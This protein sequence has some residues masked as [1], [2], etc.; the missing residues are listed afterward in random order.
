MW[1]YVWIAFM[2]GLIVATTV[3]GLREKKARDAAIKKMR[4]Q[5]MPDMGMSH[6]ASEEEGFGQADPLDGFGDPNE[7]SA[8][9][10]QSFK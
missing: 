4:P 2:L 3:V 6:A 9:D 1:P 7:V 8:F 10:E 5:T